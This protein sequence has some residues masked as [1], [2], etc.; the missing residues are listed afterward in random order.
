MR[1]L[2]LI[3]C[4]FILSYSNINAQFFVLKAEGIAGE[5]VRF[6]DKTE[7][8]G[9]VMEGSSSQS[10]ATGGGMAAGKRIYQPATI[11]KQAG[12]SSPILFQNFYTG[13]FIREIS[14][15]YYK[16]D[17]KA[18]KDILEYVITFRNVTINGFKQFAGT[19]KNE[20]FEI[21]GNNMMYDEVKFNFQEIMLDYKRG[22]IIAQDNIMR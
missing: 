15:E 10:T 20:R 18:G 9:F 5:S 13:R 21:A 4:G 14:I 3:V 12:A 22:N 17:S 8:M 19:A 7:L 6:K 16:T 1:K 2:F 11:L